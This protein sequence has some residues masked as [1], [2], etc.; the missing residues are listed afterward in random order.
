MA[1]AEDYVND[2]KDGLRLLQRQRQE[3]VQRGRRSPEGLI[4]VFVDLE[5]ALN[6]FECEPLLLAEPNR[7]YFQNPT[8]Q[9]GQTEQRTCCH[10]F[11]LRLKTGVQLGNLVKVGIRVSA[12]EYDVRKNPS[13]HSQKNNTERRSKLV[14]MSQSPQNSS[15]F[16]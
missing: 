10:V 7:R 11:D 2:G 13:V 5:S 4:A 16:L 3:L 6:I 15:H 9:E 14:S 8:S 12:L 1:D